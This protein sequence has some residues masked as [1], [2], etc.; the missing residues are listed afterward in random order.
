MKGITRRGK[1]RIRV[2][3]LVYLKLNYGQKSREC[4]FI[5]KIVRTF[6]IIIDNFLNE[7]ILTLITQRLTEIIIKLEHV[8]E[9]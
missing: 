1:V 8:L 7:N 4:V 9:R 2:F 5:E 3:C 6:F